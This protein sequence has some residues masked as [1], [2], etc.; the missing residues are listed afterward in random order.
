[1]PPDPRIG[2]VLQGRYR[3]LQ[4]LAE[5]GMGV[6]YRGE[7]M[8]LDRP[9]AIKFLHDIATSDADSR[10][11][12]EIEAKAASRMNH[13]NC[14][15]V[16]DFGVEREAPYL[17]MDFIEGQTLREVIESGPLETA[18]ALALARQMLAGL[19]HAHGHGII[20]RDLKPENVLVFRDALG[21]HARITDFGL[22]KLTDASTVTDNIAIGTPSYMSP[23]QT[24]GHRADA[25]SDVY[26]V[27]VVLF[28]LFTGKKPF[29][30]ASPFDT[31][32]LHRDAPIPAFGAVA[33][34]RKI[35]PAI[36][37]VIR[38]AL[39]K[40]PDDRYPSAIE[41][42]SALD[43]AA[44]KAPRS[45]V[46]DT[47]A[48]VA[49]VTE[50]PKWLLP[51][52][53]LGLVGIVALVAAIA[54]R[55]GDPPAPAVD[56]GVALAPVPVDAAPS[57][58]APEELP[59]VAAALALARE[60]KRS[61]AVDM[62]EALRAK[63][64]K[65]AHVSYV[66]GNINV[67]RAWWLPAVQDYADALRKHEDYKRDPRLVRDLVQALASDKAYEQASVL[68]VEKL[69]A[70]ALAEL[71]AAERSGDPQLRSRAGR[72]RARIERDQRNQ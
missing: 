23:E 58:V 47:S 18:R 15:A 70:E 32:K 10:R 63:H 67:D 28:E 61:A 21:E 59:G 17:V 27:G 50:R 71:A 62:L 36:E 26:G 8:G 46:E 2:E 22:A 30:A 56:A 12:F 33:P 4:R 24:L 1:M 34:D 60:G 57:M 3:I 53:G 55:G 54:M 6:V 44:S 65:N 16:I 41:L 14:V 48:L 19:A 52:I 20:H 11:R 5:G 37:T 40:S 72:I 39:A 29:K 68:V 69:G 49:H 66:L 43:N 31:M 9:V 42:A 45:K 35:P 7:R 13:P 38:R 25:R 51:A 64:P